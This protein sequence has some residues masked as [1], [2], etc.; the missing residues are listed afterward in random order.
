MRT[1]EWNPAWW[2]SYGIMWKNHKCWDQ[3]V[4]PAVWAYNTTQLVLNIL[5]YGRQPRGSLDLKYNL[6][7]KSFKVLSQVGRRL[8]NEQGKPGT[9]RLSDIIRISGRF[10][11]AVGDQVWW[12]KPEIPTTKQNKKMLPK[13]EGPY[14]LSE[15]ISAL[16]Y[17]I[18]SQDQKRVC[19]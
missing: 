15:K 14:T 6:P 16:L 5:L 10:P 8:L 13:R 1:V 3:F 17:M 11:L 4:S 18:Q 7:V 2:P 19:G 9:S 12:Q